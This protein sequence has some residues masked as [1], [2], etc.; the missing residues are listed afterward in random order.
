MLNFV[1]QVS[2]RS[3]VESDAASLGGSRSPSGSYSKVAPQSSRLPPSP[4]GSPFP[5]ARAGD[6]TDATPLGGRVGRAGGG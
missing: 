2:V 6:R 5:P 4:A 1:I 3:V